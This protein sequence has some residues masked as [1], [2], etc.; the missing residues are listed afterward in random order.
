VLLI[1]GTFQEWLKSGC[2]RILNH[3]PIIS[4]IAGSQQT[5]EKGKD[6]IER[7]FGTDK[8]LMLAD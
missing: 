3:I 2:A 5:R 1:R 8:I 4:N 6:K 7:I